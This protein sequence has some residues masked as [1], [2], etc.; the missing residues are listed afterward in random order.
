M[1]DRP[2]V[3]QK[4]ASDLRAKL[5]QVLVALLMLATLAVYVLAAVLAI[6]T[7]RRP[8]LGAFVE[9]TLVVNRVGE[10]DWTG[11]A[12]GLDL[13]DHLVALDGQPLTHPQSLYD[14][15][16]GY[17]AGDIV[18]LTVERDDGSR[19]Q[20]TVTLQSFPNSALIGYF[21]FPYGIGLAYLLIGL[22]V[23]V[24]RREKA[25]GR[26]F[27]LFCV[28]FALATGLLFDLYTTHRLVQV[29]V[30]GLATVGGS[31]I[32][33]A[34]VFPQ[35]SRFVRRW[36]WLSLL[37]YTLSGLIALWALATT[38]DLDNPWAYIPAWRPLY[39][40]TALG[41]LLWVAM[42]LRRR[43]R[44][45]SPVVR[46]QTRVILLGVL[47]ASLP[48]VG[49]FFLASL[50][51]DPGFQP[52]I[53][54]APLVLL[55]LSI[56]YA[57]LRYRLLDVDLLISRGVSY[58][59]LTLLIVGGYAVLI[60][61][62]GLLLGSTIEANHP[63]L[64]ALFVLAVTLAF[65]P[66]RT[67][68]HHAVEQLFYRDRIN[69]RQELEAYSHELGR[70]LDQADIFAALAARVEAA[71]HPRRL[72][73]FLYDETAAQ[74]APVSPRKGPSGGVR[75]SPDGGLAHLLIEQQGSL[76]LMVGQPLPEELT[77][78]A[79]Q[80]EA[81]G[82]SLYVP[83]PKH[84]WMA[85]GERRSGEPYLTDDL[86]YLE[87]LGDQ[88]SLALDRV[89]L[90]S[91]LERRLTE[92]NALRWVSQAIHF[93]VE[94]DTLLELIYAQTSKVLDTTN[95]YIALYNEA[96]ETLSFA[97]YVENGERYDMTDEWPLEMGGLH[98]EIIRYGQPIVTDDYMSECLRR[99]ISPGGKAERAWMGVPLNAGER[100]IGVM[101]VSSSEPGV[102]YSPDQLSIFSAIAHQAA[103][104]IDKTR[105]DKEMEERTLQLST[106][107]EVASAIN[108]TLDLDTVLDMITQKAV[109][110]LDAESGT[111]FLTDPDTGEHVFQVAVGPS[112]GE[113]VGLRLAPDKGIVGAAA[114]TQEPMIVNDAQQDERWF[115]ETDESSGY[116]TRALLAVPLINKGQSIG[117][118]EV[119]NKADGSAFDD[120][121]AQLMQAFA[122]QAAIALENA[123]L[124]TMTDQALAER[125]E[126]LSMFQKIDQALNSTLDYRHVMELTLDWAMRVT[127]AEVGSVANLD[128][129]RGGLFI[130]SSRGYPQEYEQYRDKPW[131]V[132]KGLIGRAVTTGKPV[133]VG[134]VAADP[135]YV[136]A[137]PESRSQLAVPFRLGEEVI[138]VISLESPEV[139]GFSADDVQFATRLAERAVVP[140]ENAK[141]YEQVKRANEA[142]SQFVS[143][144]AHELKN[145]LTSIGGYARLLELSDG[146][147]DETKKSFTRTITANVERMR[148]TVEDL[149]D[150]SRIE[151]GLLKLEME[152]VSIATVIGET[153]DSL[154]N[155]IDE[156]GLEL[157]LAIPE[158]LPLVWG[159]R[160]RLVQVLVNIVDNARK[161]TPEGSITITAE[162]V[163][164]LL[165]DNGRMGR[166]VRCSVRD[167]GIGI[168]QEDQERLFKS[169]FVR[170]DNGREVAQG[171][172]L[173][174]WLI[175]RLAR[176][177][178]GE[179]TVES[180][181]GQGSTFSL[182]M[183]VANGRA[184]SAR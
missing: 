146:P 42:L 100:V 172:G 115:S 1:T 103:A 29:W 106:L 102:R 156:K 104:I 125:V 63:A 58:G 98:A 178:G 48:L 173:G 96:K 110:I 7:A 86:G 180:E 112:A 166:F 65:N 157:N 67:H 38:T 6:Q 127:G 113:L 159:D 40:Y 46:E 155:A 90:I 154:R 99:G 123:R 91:D 85:L 121:D 4:G 147:M 169:Q 153:L 53:L 9:P 72:L 107:N 33:L 27:A 128:E 175:N 167:T 41:A 24:A 93:S 44:T 51:V 131:L 75:F 183:P 135:D 82:A 108:S 92:L 84:G 71:V 18:T 97:F 140:I 2:V 170:F 134:D 122:S 150:I 49:W 120:Q 25:A 66:L 17:K 10:N 8:F 13:P 5:V 164:L 47:V 109:E 52:T 54:F 145:P 89:E 126:E 148:T 184:R 43:I 83:V 56:G 73:F 70:L 141:L 37:V 181:L 130:V 28:A 114:A 74:F 76:Y 129:E 168:S 95:F 32:H 35:R 78:E 182:V 26:A 64:V 137:V 116:F 79:H 16:S 20:V 36:P 162:V 14:Q 174:L 68:L 142:K 55:P 50:Q 118:L 62:L 151:R 81:V 158:D 15:L 165:Q 60:N 177:Q 88:T 161:Y 171:Y 12:A 57:I 39:F 31:L 45:D 77:R 117:V 22:V 105:L 119:L 143:M 30:I 61:L 101:N 21:V 179:I 34:L 152:G 149:L 3:N 144:V 133:L 132:S 23:F 59:L 139:G 19:R 136:M 176:M 94:L 87:A 124:F 160:T 11:R 80:L 138:G 111:L 163:K 69:Y